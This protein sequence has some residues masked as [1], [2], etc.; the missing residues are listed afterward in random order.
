MA[1]IARACLVFDRPTGILALI[2]A[3]FEAI[4]LQRFLNGSLRRS[5]LI[6]SPA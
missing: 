6:I 4:F 1:P 3:T 2:L 5:I